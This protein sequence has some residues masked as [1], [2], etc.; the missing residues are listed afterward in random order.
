MKNNS[1]WQISEEKEDKKEGKEFELK[2]QS[3]TVSWASTAN[4]NP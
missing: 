2:G 4:Q 1:I 3:W